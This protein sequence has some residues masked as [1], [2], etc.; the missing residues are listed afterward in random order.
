MNLPK[1]VPNNLKPRIAHWDDERK[2]GNSLIVTL[3]YGWH[4][5]DGH[6]IGADNIK[7]AIQAVRNSEP[8][9]CSECMANAMG[10]NK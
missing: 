7:E 1:S 2:L 10:A 9:N 3:A 6:V 8:C 4:M 5:G